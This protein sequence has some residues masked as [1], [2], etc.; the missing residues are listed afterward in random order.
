VSLVDAS[1]IARRFGLGSKTQPIVNT[2]ILGA[3]AAD[4]GMVGLEAICEAIAEAIPG[5]ADLNIQAAREA[6]QSVVRVPVQEVGH[7]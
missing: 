1:A 3:F 2:S 6:A 4:S 5:K 7:V